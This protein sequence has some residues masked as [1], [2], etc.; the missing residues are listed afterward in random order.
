VQE[1]SVPVH[2]KVALIDGNVF[3]GADYRPT[4]IGEGNLID[5]TARTP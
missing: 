2:A 3:A 5:T 1:I 4:E